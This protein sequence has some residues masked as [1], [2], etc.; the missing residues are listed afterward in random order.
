MQYFPGDNILSFFRDGLRQSGYS[1][2]SS[3]GRVTSG[4]GSPRSNSVFTIGAASNTQYNRK[5]RELLRR[6]SF[7]VFN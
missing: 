4:Q 7:Y 5:K 3:S 1:E 6:I 2:G